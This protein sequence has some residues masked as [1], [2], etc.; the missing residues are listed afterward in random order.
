M[1]RVRLDS[2]E[3][4]TDFQKSSKWDVFT[5]VKLLELRH[6]LALL[7]DG[8]LRRALEGDGRGLLEDVLCRGL[9]LGE[10]VEVEVRLEQ[11]REAAPVVHYLV[12]LD[13]DGSAL[14]VIQGGR[15]RVLRR[16]EV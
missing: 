3:L 1:R 6:A 16:D 15:G 14:S 8:R 12:K 7:E 11:V 10:D 4:I 5:W 9:R 13:V 2:G